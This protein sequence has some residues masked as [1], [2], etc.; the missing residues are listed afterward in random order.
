MAINKFI[1]N[2]RQLIIQNDVLSIL[3]ANIAE[4]DENEYN[5]FLQGE[6]ARLEPAVVQA[7]IDVFKL[8][9]GSY[10][11]AENL[12]GD[13]VIE[14]RSD[15]DGFNTL[16][17]ASFK[18][19]GKFALKSNSTPNAEY[20]LL[21]IYTAYKITKSDMF[22]TDDNGEILEFN[23]FKFLRL[24]ADIYKELKGFSTDAFYDRNGKLYELDFNSSYLPRL[25]NLISTKSLQQGEKDTD[26]KAFFPKGFAFVDVFVKDNVEQVNNVNFQEIESYNTTPDRKFDIDEEILIAENEERTKDFVVSPS[27]KEYLDNFYDLSVAGC[28]PTCCAFYGPSGA[29][30]TVSAQVIARELHRPYVSFKMKEN[31]DEDSLKG[32]IKSINGKEILYEDTPVVKALKNGWVCEIQELSVAT[33]QGA[34]TFFNPILDKSRTFEDASGK[35]FNVH[36]DALLIFT[37]NPNYCENNQIATSLLNRIEDQY[38]IEFPDIETVCQI[39]QKETRFNDLEKLRKIYKLCFGDGTEMASIK[40]YL[41]ENDIEEEL[42]LRQVINWIKHYMT[43][44]RYYNQNNGWVNAAEHTIIQTLGQRELEV[45]EDIRGIIDAVM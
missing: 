15:N 41:E 44:R 26:I 21:K 6:T 24:C 23:T 35:T 45:Q 8:N 4:F 38:M 14:Y 32:T 22:K 39:I 30:K 7:A 43:C 40:N 33:N 10:C 36:P 11:V 34:E 42:S 28:A 19:I 27:C 16:S 3:K 18:G 25:K 1:T 5:Q 29:G 37:F 9:K 12:V 31:S 17:V 13:A 20:E 2:V